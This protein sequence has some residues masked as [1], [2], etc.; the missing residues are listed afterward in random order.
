[1]RTV[2]RASRLLN[3]VMC[4]VTVLCVC[5]GLAAPLAYAQ[6]VSNATLDSMRAALSRYRD[7]VLA[8]HDG[9]FSTV[10]C[11]HIPR[12]GEPG[13]VPYRPGG[14]G[15]H[16]LNMQT[17]SPVPS[18][19]RP[20]VLLYEP[21]GDSLRLIGAE[22][23]IPLATGVRE[24]P[25]LLGQPFDGPMEGHHPLMPAD[26]THYDLHVWLYKP[27]PNGI[28]SATN[29]NVRCGNYRYRMSEQAPRLVAEPTR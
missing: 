29:S 4:R 18:P 2:I 13:Q 7:V 14:M 23:F 5:A 17:I 8:V 9:Y 25:Q 1:M 12:A 21:D 22:W 6:N 11:V 26:L 20:Q 3:T 19:D 15:V 10:Y 28:F 24:R 16:F 27:N